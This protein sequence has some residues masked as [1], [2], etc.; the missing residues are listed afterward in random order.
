MNGI[1]INKLIRSSR[2]TI[3]LIVASDAALV[4]RAP[5]KTPLAYIEDLIA[6]KKRWILR[7]KEQAL[8]NY[9]PAE[10][11][12]FQ[13]GEKFLFLGKTY[14][15]KISSVWEIELREE[16]IFPERFLKNAA[17]KMMTWYRESAFEKI[18]ERAR[19][20][21]QI[22]GWKY[23]LIRI[24]NAQ[25]R[26]GSCSR[27]NA[28]NFTWRLV[29]APP[30]VLD[31]VVV[32]ELAHIPEKNHSPRFWNKVEMILPNYQVQREWLRKNGANLVF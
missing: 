22:S 16:L 15:L 17:E 8:K 26:W 31:Y 28:L 1:K 25:G 5:L 6:Q 30:E 3:A 24:N 27:G 21:S 13:N 18:T 7:K 20:Y 2:K 23:S 4:V 32:H 14:P 29:M 19:Y 11:K 12:E 10:K 9:F